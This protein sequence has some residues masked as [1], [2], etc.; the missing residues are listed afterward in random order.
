M[1]FPVMQVVL[2]CNRWEQD[3]INIQVP[4]GAIK[5][6]YKKCLLTEEDISMF[7]QDVVETFF[8]SPKKRNTGS[9]NIVSKFLHH[10]YD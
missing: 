7:P 3:I 4:F 9:E 8:L 1:F 10:F 5:Y 2:I 6:F